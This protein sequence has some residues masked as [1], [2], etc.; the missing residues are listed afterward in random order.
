MNA[1]QEPKPMCI[2]ATFNDAELVC[3][4]TGIPSIDR[5]IPASMV[6][7][8]GNFCIRC[9]FG[10]AGEVMANGIVQWNGS[11]WSSRGAGM[12]I[13]QSPRPSGERQQSICRGSFTTAGGMA[14]NATA[15][16]R[17]TS[18]HIATCW[19]AWNITKQRHAHR[20]LKLASHLGP[21]RMR[22]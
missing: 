3:M 21:G 16:H 8:T 4:N 10:A 5:V 22:P 12:D 1:T 2:K 20:L 6:D 18:P 15:R 9:K 13:P 14:A 11:G 7:S 19:C 17:H